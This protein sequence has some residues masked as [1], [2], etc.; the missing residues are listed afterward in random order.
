MSAPGR[1]PEGIRD[2]SGSV[3]SLALGGE[4][5]SEDRRPISTPGRDPEGVWDR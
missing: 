5:K 1:D 4:W 3:T 2:R